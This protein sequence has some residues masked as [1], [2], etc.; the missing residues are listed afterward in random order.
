M[1]QK[2]KKQKQKTK[3]TGCKTPVTKPNTAVPGS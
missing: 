1:S 2:K 3:T